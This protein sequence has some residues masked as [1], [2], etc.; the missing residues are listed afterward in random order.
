MHFYIL[1]AARKKLRSGM[2]FV[3]QE[4]IETILLIIDHTIY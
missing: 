1:L 2:L 4:Q 3:R